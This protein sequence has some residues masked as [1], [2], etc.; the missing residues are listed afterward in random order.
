MEKKKLYTLY[1]P[2]SWGY[3]D[4]KL[5]LH[6]IVLFTKRHSSG[7]L[8]LAQIWDLERHKP[9]GTRNKYKSKF[10]FPLI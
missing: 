10:F 8:K 2:F 7:L 5:V 9:H 3:V 6:S 1:T 4:G